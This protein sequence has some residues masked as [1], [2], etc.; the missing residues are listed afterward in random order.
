MKLNSLSLV[1]I[2][3]ESEIYRFKNNSKDPN[4]PLHFN[5]L[6][7]TLPASEQN[8]LLLNNKLKFEDDQLITVTI[9]DVNGTIL[10]TSNNGCK[11]NC[12]QA[13][14]II[15]QLAEANNNAFQITYFDYIN[16]I[17]Q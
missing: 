16:R 3:E 17:A 5:H 4:N 6:Y 13:K 2:L 10:F 12:S 14:E 9:T 8:A 15:F 1:F 7:T 11:M